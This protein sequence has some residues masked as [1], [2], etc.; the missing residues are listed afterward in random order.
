[1]VWFTVSRISVFFLKVWNL[2]KFWP[3][4]KCASGVLKF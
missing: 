2:S 4:L 1:M 3:P